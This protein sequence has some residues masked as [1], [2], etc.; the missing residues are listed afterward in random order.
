VKQCA[1]DRNKLIQ[2]VLGAT[3]LV[4]LQEISRSGKSEES[5]KHLKLLKRG[6]R[7]DVSR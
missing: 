1:R 4:E 7:E 3:E 6:R 5:E 2:L